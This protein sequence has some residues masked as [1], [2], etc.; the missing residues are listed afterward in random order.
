MEAQSRLCEPVFT[1]P[2]SGL[3]WRTWKSE[4]NTRQARNTSYNEPLKRLYGVSRCDLH[5]FRLLNTKL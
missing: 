5:L 4:N 3:S 1:S 2:V